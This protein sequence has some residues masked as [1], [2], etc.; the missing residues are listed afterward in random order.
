MMDVTFVLTHDCNLGCSYCYAGRKFRKAMPVEV[1]DAALDLGFSNITKGST[2]Q[3][4]YFGGEP[5][6][7]WDLL[8]QTAFMARTRATEVGVMLSQSVTTNGTLLTREKVERLAELGIDVALSIDGSRAAHEAERPMMGGQSSFDS[9][10]SGLQCLLAAGRSFDVIS[11]VTPKNVPF[12]G[13]S[14]KYLFD[15]GVPRLNLNVA[16]EARWTEA[17]LEQLKSGLVQAARITADHFRSGRIVSFS[18]FDAKV[19]TRAAGG[20]RPEDTCPIGEGS[21]AVAPSGN[22]YPCERLVG[23]DEDLTY[24]IGN[25]QTGLN[26]KNVSTHRDSMPNYH[27]T[28]AECIDCGER[29][30]CSAFCACANLAETNNIAI[31]GGV[32]CLYERVTMEIA[33]TLYDV[34]RSERN[35]LYAEWLSLNYD[36]LL[37]P[38]PA[39][40]LLAI[41]PAN[42]RLP[43]VR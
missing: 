12:L 39:P 17:S 33:D 19:R 11:V 35:A 8:V 21:I 5:L 6:L 28:N 14:V 2:L 29:N 4:C 10:V 43:V 22:L 9:V 1:R 32:Q 16:F 23:E 18:V 30:R 24:V 15:L 36:E 25:T 20:L 26:Q 31:A 27:A 41:R 40:A 34:M 3:L 7:E 37:A 38:M 13:E 42:G